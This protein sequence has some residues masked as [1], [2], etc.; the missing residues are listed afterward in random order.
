MEVKEINLSCL[1]QF[2]VFEFDWIPRKR[3]EKIS[4]RTQTL[5]DYAES[6][7]LVHFS[8]ASTSHSY[9]YSYLLTGAG[10]DIGRASLDVENSSRRGSKYLRHFY[11]SRVGA[12]GS[13]VIKYL[14]LQEAVYKIISFSD[15]RVTGHQVSCDFSSKKLEF[16]QEEINNRIFTICWLKSCS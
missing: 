1:E 7:H 12:M 13:E 2:R 16:H 15:L 3:N 4:R 5:I 9:P 14:S 10:N 8:R 11:R 6:E